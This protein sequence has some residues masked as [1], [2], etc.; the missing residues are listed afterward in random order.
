MQKGEVTAFLS[1]IFILLMAMVGGLMESASIHM[2]KNY[3]RAD[4]NRALESV[5]AEYQKELL[6]N[7]D[8]F[9][10]ETS[11]E[12]GMYSEDYIKK[13][14]AYFGA[15]GMDHDIQKIEF[16]TDNNARAFYEQILYYMEHKYGLN[17]MKNKISMTDL[18]KK[19]EKD[20]KEYRKEENEKWGNLEDLLQDEGKKLPEEN[21]PIGYVDDLKQTPLLNLI[22]PEGMTVSGKSF[23]LD[24]SLSVREKNQGYGDFTDESKDTGTMSNLLF[25]EYLLTH[26]FA[27]T[28]SISDK[29]TDHAKTGVLDYELEYICA[30]KRSDRE[31]L[32]FIA[33]KILL[34]RFGTNFLFLI[35]SAAKCAQAETLALTLC[36]LAAVPALSE[37]VKHAILLAW[38]YGESIMD[39]RVLLKGQK[40]PYVK[41]EESWQLSLSGLMKLKE[42]GSINDGKNCSDGISYKEYLRMILFL[43]KKEK[44]SMRALD[45]IEQNMKKKYGLDFFRAD[46]CL[47][48]IQIKSR[49]SLR[50]G[51]TYEFFTY[52]GYQ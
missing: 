11:Y 27:A 1:L 32:E 8:I 40:V 41:S 51:V 49:C 50:R 39:L 31:N 4:V 17:M 22:V 21:N 2:A 38:S 18:W 28:D 10:L 37:A 36:S 25:G 29:K 24:E 9:A 14:L 19:Q 35:N 43:E 12:R 33:K 34:F 15:G 26:F 20:S 52:F 45:M 5:F 23:N 3:R 7:Y 13:R 48:K 6:E 46:F 44:I 30:G 42:N 47:S 16:L